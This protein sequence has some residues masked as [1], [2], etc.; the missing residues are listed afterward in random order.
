MYTKEERLETLL[1]LKT[2]W[3][4]IRDH[5]GKD[6]QAKKDAYSALGL[7][8]DR[9]C[10]PAC[11]LAA[12]HH[13]TGGNNAYCADGTPRHICVVRWDEAGQ[14]CVAS[15]I[16]GPKFDPEKVLEKIYEALDRES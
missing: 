13:T 16:Y 7:A 4:W 2:V 5:G 1:K 14:G 11:E 3:E 8:A 6:Y 15:G 12:K 10:C 9:S